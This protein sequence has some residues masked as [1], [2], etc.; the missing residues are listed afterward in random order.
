MTQRLLKRAL[1]Q[2]KR[3]TPHVF[4]LCSTSATDV[5]AAVAE[6][7]ET[8][9]HVAVI[10]PPQILTMLHRR[11]SAVKPWCTVFCWKYLQGGHSGKQRERGIIQGKKCH[12]RCLK[13]G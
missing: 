5:D 7:C 10:H 11:M 6:A 13:V 2:Q 8:D 12:H 1:S 4:H 9:R 3:P